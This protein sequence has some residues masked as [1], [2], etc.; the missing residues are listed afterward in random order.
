[1]KIEQANKIAPKRKA[2]RRGAPLPGKPF[3]EVISECSDVELMFLLSCAKP[4]KY[5]KA[6]SELCQDATLSESIRALGA[7]IARDGAELR[8]LEAEIATN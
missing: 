8:S 7:E 3:M 2:A 4:E 6:Y 1:M 5:G